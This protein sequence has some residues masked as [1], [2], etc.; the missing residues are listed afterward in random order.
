MLIILRN[1][2]DRPCICSYMYRFLSGLVAALFVPATLAEVIEIPCTADTTLHEIFPSNNMGAST[3][4]AVG[5]TQHLAD[6]QPTRARGLF[7]F[8]LTNTVPAGATINSVSISFKVLFTPG[9]SPVPANFELYRMNK[10][11]TEGRG[12]GN[13]GS[14]ALQGEP[15]WINQSTPV[16]WNAPGALEDANPEVRSSVPVLGEGVWVMP[17]T[18]ALIA[19]VGEFLANPEINFGWMMVSSAESTPQS[20]KRVGSREVPENAARL[21]IDYTPPA[22]DLVLGPVE[23]STGKI[24]LTWN[25]SSPVDLQKSTNFADWSDYLLSIK[26]NSAEVPV[27]DNFGWFRLRSSSQ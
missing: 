19:D 25:G 10:P 20:V 18:T 14:Q 17:S 2:A 5:A 7:R 4:I 11:W 15:S 26:T 21:V 24:R 22:T 27:T 6:G 16:A 12:T 1:P 13:G 3:H 23:L 8:N 9:A